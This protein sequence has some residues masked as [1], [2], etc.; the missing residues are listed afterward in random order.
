MHFY[1]CLAQGA[2]QEQSGREEERAQAGCGQDPGGQGLPQKE[3]V[4]L[5]GHEGELCQI[6]VK[7]NR[8]EA[9]VIKGQRDWKRYPFLLEAGVAS[10]QAAQRGLSQQSM[11]RFQPLLRSPPSARGPG[12]GHHPYSL[13]W[14]PWKSLESGQGN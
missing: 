12:A 8:R 1:H 3:G 6:R 4:F 10:H 9:F 2:V 11:C 5:R 13:R 14:L 7:A